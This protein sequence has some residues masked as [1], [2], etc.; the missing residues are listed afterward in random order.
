MRR[1]HKFIQYA[2]VLAQLPQKNRV[3]CSWRRFRR[4]HIVPRCCGVPT[5]PAFPVWLCLRDVVS[6]LSS[7]LSPPTAGVV[8]GVITGQPVFHLRKRGVSATHHSGAVYG[9]VHEDLYLPSH[10]DLLTRLSVCVYIIHTARL[11]GRLV[12]RV[13]MASCMQRVPRKSRQYADRPAPAQGTRPAAKERVALLSGTF[14]AKF[15]G[16]L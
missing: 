13:T 4:F 1:C 9:D 3:V 2:R 10:E 8:R 12:A 7:S 15:S 5:F 11:Y 16:V 6:S 14:L